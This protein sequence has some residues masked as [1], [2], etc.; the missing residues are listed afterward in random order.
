MPYKNPA[1]ARAAEKRWREENP[2]RV[3]E[4]HR[5]YVAADPERA[6]DKSR[7][8]RAAHPEH[9]RALHAAEMRRWRAANPGEVRAM[10]RWRK[11]GLTPEAFAELVAAHDG[12]CAI[13]DRVPKRLV[14]DHDHDT[15]V[16]RGLLCDPCNI[17]VGWIEKEGLAAALAYLQKHQP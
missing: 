1:D 8:W 4:Y 16:V 12:H 7:R 15:G 13:C 14:I 3:R 9:S 5:Q 11:Y 17:R 6:R 2:E 10:D